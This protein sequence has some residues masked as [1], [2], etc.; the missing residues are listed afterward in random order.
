M[1]DYETG[2]EFTIDDSELDKYNA[3]FEITYDEDGFYMEY[4]AR[5]AKIVPALFI[6]PPNLQI[7]PV[8]PSYASGYFLPAHFETLSMKDERFVDLTALDATVL[9]AEYKLIEDFNGI[10]K[11]KIYNCPELPC[12]YDLFYPDD[13]D[14]VGDGYEKI[15]N[16]LTELY[17]LAFFA[18]YNP[19]QKLLRAYTHMKVRVNFIRG[20]KDSIAEVDKEIDTDMPEYFD[21]QGKTVKSPRKGVMYVKRLGTKTTLEI[22]EN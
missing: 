13:V 1:L 7:W 16:K 8:C 18:Q 3:H 5:Y 21:L 12:D 10:S 11:I 6:Y 17:F 4:D 20:E 14:I 19:K 9:E 15:N 22:F 2:E